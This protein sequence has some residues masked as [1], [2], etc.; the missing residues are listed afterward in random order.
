MV[1]S[2]VAT[3]D[4][5]I[6]A[7]SRLGESGVGETGGN[8]METGLAVLA[9]LPGNLPGSFPDLPGLRVFL[10]SVSL[11]PFLFPEASRIF[12]DCGNLIET[13]SVPFLL[14]VSLPGS[15]PDL[16]GLRC[17]E[18]NGFWAVSPSRFSSRKLPGSSRIAAFCNSIK[19]STIMDPVSGATEKPIINHTTYV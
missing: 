7:W 14:P 17:F 11:F 5:E 4:H 18:G 16:P 9:S 12:P 3:F 2:R 1:A 19:T 13:V 10:K 6:D 8:A 15:F